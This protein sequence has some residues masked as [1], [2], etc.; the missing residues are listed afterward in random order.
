[1]ST[2]VLERVETACVERHSSL[3]GG[4]DGLPGWLVRHWRTPHGGY[5][6]GWDRASQMRTAIET[7]RRTRAT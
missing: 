4:A 3:A 5:G 7:F 1:M 6:A 2:D